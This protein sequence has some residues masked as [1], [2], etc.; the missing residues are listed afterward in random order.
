MLILNYIGVFHIHEFPLSQTAMVLH[1]ICQ[2]DY[3]LVPHISFE[4]YL[5]RHSLVVFS[6][7]KFSL[8]SYPDA[9]PLFMGKVCNFQGT[10]YN[11]RG[12]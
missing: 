3:I 6:L 5:G 10:R 1:G 8:V 11:P 4:I 7:D 2:G 12:V 9:F